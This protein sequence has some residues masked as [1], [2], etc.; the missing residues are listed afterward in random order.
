MIVPL[1]RKYTV[2]KIVKNNKAGAGHSGKSKHK[3]PGPKSYVYG[4]FVMVMDDATRGHVVMKRKED[5]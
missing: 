2:H 5:V 1:K 3:V 4:D